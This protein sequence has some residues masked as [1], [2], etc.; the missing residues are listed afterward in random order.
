MEKQFNFV[1]INRGL[2]VLLAVFLLI[3]FAGQA[4]AAFRA[5]DLN[6]K[7]RSGDYTR[8]VDNFLVILD[9]SGSM[10]SQSSGAALAG[11]SGLNKFEA[12]KEILKRMNQTIPK[13]P[14]NGGLRSFGFN[15]CLSWNDTVLN[16]R[17]TQY[18][19]S[20]FQN[21]L[22]SQSCA[23]GGSAMNMALDHAVDD[24]ASAKGNIAVFVVS[25]GK[26]GAART[27]PYAQYLKEQYGDR[28]CIYSIWVGDGEQ[29]KQL[30]EEI[31]NI[32]GCGSFVSATN[33]ASAQNMGN[34]VES[35]FLQ[36]GPGRPKPKVI[37]DGDGDGVLDDRDLCPKTYKGI[38]VNEIGCWVGGR[39]LFDFDKAEIKP[40]AYHFLDEIA[41]LIVKAK[42]V[43]PDARLEVDGY[44]DSIGNA[45]YNMD[46]SRRRAQAVVDYLVAHGAD[47]DQ[48]VARGF[49]KENPLYSN[50]TAENRAKNR[51]VQLTTLPY[52]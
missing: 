6:G 38:R 14:I 16:S 48:L 50:D 2:K 31:A 7:I 49:G 3:S 19:Q 24:L 22:D 18:T 33:I 43:I 52:K 23:S 25:D 36:K 15:S 13:L 32:G 27:L 26:T 40:E 10:D 4:A 17:M 11:S 41:P 46:L 12:G 47:P 35:A 8:K 30:M 21:G 51:R 34:F 42:T 5:V 20:G 45:E 39:V 44:T 29:G 28:L 9:A 37:G 1:G